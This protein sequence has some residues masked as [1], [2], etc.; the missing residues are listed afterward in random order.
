M[1]IQKWIQRIETLTYKFET[2]HHPQR[3]IRLLCDLFKKLVYL[4]KDLLDF[5]TTCSKNYLCWKDLKL[6]LDLFNRLS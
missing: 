3:L 2:R 4:F 6:I 5:Y 1:A